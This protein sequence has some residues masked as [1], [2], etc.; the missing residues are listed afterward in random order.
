VALLTA[1]HALKRRVKPLNLKQ[2]TAA[3]GGWKAKDIDPPR[4]NA[5]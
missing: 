5:T 3:F 4:S 2:L 1:E